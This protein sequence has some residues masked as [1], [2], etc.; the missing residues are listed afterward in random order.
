MYKPI[1]YPLKRTH[2]QIKTL[3]SKTFFTR[4]IWLFTYNYYSPLFLSIRLLEYGLTE[5]IIFLHTH[6][7]MHEAT[8]K[9]K[10]RF[11][12][13]ATLTV[14]SKH[15]SI[16]RGVLWHRAG[17]VL[18]TDIRR[19]VYCQR[20]FYTLKCTK[21]TLQGK[22]SLIRIDSPKVISRT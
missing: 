8:F 21:M 5:K 9:I 11:K 18:A 20:I 1:S 19:G 22:F 3:F 6:R 2:A 16:R 14:A 17:S 4:L 13:D 15:I 12:M 10:K 7:W